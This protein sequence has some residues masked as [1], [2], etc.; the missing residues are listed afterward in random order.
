MATMAGECGDGCLTFSA[1]EMSLK[2]SVNY[3][4]NY[5]YCY[6]FYCERG[7]WFFQI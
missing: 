1:D 6:Y 2:A 3:C 7:K 4:F 5:Y